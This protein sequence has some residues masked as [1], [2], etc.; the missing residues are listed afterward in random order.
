MCKES[1]LSLSFSRRRSAITCKICQTTGHLKDSQRPPKQFN[2]PSNFSKLPNGPKSGR[3]T[4]RGIVAGECVGK[5]VWCYCIHTVASGRQRMTR[6]RCS[7]NCTPCQPYKS[8][9]FSIFC[10][11]LLYHVYSLYVQSHASHY[12]TSFSP[13]SLSVS[14]TYN[15]RFSHSKNT[16]CL[17]QS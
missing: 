10:V 17:F 8:I 4:R 7:F 12:I 14:F 1:M 11:I 9:Q 15:G 2:S 5:M 16:L 13:D 3:R 6:C